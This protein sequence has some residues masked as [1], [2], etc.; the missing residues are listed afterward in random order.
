MIKEK[1]HSPIIDVI[2]DLE[3]VLSDTKN[4]KNSRILERAINTLKEHSVTIHT[5]NSAIT[6]F[7]DDDFEVDSLAGYSPTVLGLS[8][9]K[10][11][12]GGIQYV[13][14]NV[15]ADYYGVTTETVRNWIKGGEISGR[16]FSNRGKYFIPK[17]EFDYLKKL[18]EKDDMDDVMSEFLGEE[19]GDD[20]DVELE[21]N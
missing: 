1:K 17:E 14:T 10:T 18:R 3:E 12:V 2:S 20:W 13:G 8:E 15:V 7:T 4:K 9:D 6:F 19:F 11:E 16:Q 21:E 5:K